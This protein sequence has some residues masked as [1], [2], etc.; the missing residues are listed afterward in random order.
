MTNA[1]NGYKIENNRLIRLSDGMVA[2]VVSRDFGAGWSTWGE[3]IDPCNPKVAIGVLLGELS[4]VVAGESEYPD[5]YHGGLRTTEIEWLPR[6]TKFRIS[7]FDGA[8][9]IVTSAELIFT[10]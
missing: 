3:A 5:E 8:E 6:G 1:P 10:A 4:G 7:E 2:V 9:S